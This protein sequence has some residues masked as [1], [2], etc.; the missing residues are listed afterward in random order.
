MFG[1][2]PGKRANDDAV[3]L[4]GVNLHFSTAPKSTVATTGRMLDRIGFEVRNLAAFCQRL[5]E[6]G[7]TLDIRYT[8]DPSGMATALLTDPW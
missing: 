5:E 3:D 2:I 4:P 6:M 1:G 8:K 7:V